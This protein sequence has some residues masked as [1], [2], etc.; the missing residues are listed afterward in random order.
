M[1]AHL[2]EPLQNKLY[3]IQEKILL[4]KKTNTNGIMVKTERVGSTQNSGL[5]FPLKGEQIC[6]EGIHIVGFKSIR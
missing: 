6:D 2:A 1:F 4:L 3:A 5:Q